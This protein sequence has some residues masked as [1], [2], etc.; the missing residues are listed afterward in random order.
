MNKKM[1][2]LV[3]S[4]ATVL[5]V[6]LTICGVWFVRSGSNGLNEDPTTN[7]PPS[8]SSTATD[9]NP[10][11]ENPLPLDETPVNKISAGDVVMVAISAD[12]IRDMYGYQLCV[13]YDK[14]LFRY[15]GGLKSDIAEIGLIFK[16]QLEFDDYVLVGA[17][18]IG[19][20]SGFNGK[21]VQIC[22]MT[23]TAI[24]DCEVADISIN[25][26]FIVQDSSGGGLIAVTNWN[27][28]VV[29]V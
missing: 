5:I 22:H 10:T 1:K 19:G 15:S 26:V 21:D 7:Q 17:L 11:Q 3:L 16:S 20:N 28:E 18:K 23:F 9:T 12:D 4:S 27:C 2:P 14:D 25:G 6:C 29:V 8:S 13:T 24:Q